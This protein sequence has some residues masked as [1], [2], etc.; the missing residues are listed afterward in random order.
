MCLVCGRVDDT[1]I[2]HHIESFGSGG[3]DEL[4]NMITLCSVCHDNAHKGF[5]DW[6]KLNVPTRKLIPPPPGYMGGTM[7]KN[8]TPVKVW[9]ADKHLGRILK[10]FYGGD[11]ATSS[12][13]V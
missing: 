12:L 9:D 5:I 2:G 7:A 4:S 13:P 3:A 10:E 11:D 6:N 8:Y 1:L